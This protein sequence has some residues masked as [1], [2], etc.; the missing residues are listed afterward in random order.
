MH[1]ALATA[2]GGEDAFT[3]DRL[4]DLHTV[5]AGFSSLVFILKCD[6]DFTT[7]LKECEQIWEALAHN[8]E[9]PELLVCEI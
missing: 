8:P 9:L 7:L 6:A 2:A 5:G 4:S 1:V 3:R